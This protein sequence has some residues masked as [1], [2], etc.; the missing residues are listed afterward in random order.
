MKS[1][2]VPNRVERKVE[3]VWEP[4]RAAVDS[5]SEGFVL[6]DTDDRLVL[7]NPK[8]VKMY[9]GITDILQPG[10]KFEDVIRT[11]AERD[12][13]HLG[14]MSVEEYVRWRVELHRRLSG[15][16]EYHLNDGRC[17]LVNEWSTS[18][19]CTVS[20]H[21]DIT[22]LKHRESDLTQKSTLLQA[23]FDNIAEGISVFDK[24]LRLVAWNDQYLEAVGL[25]R[26]LARV[27]APIEELLR[28]RAK[29]GSYGPAETESH[30]RKRMKHFKRFPSEVFEVTRPDGRIF[31][32]RRQ[33]FPGGGIVTTYTDVTERKCTEEA[34]R[35]SQTW[36]KHAQHVAKVGHWVWYGPNIN[37]WIRDCGK[38]YRPPM[39]S[40]EVAR[41]FGIARN[42]TFEGEIKQEWETHPDDVERCAETLERAER[43]QSSYDIE[44][45]IVHPD[46]DVRTVHEIGELLHDEVGDE[47]TWVGVVQDVSAQTR[48]EADLISS[49]SRYRDLFEQSP[50]GIWEEDYSA[51]KEIIDGLRRR[52]VRNFRRYF[53]KHP[54]TLRKAIKA[55][56]VLDVNQAI[57]DIYR[58]PNKEAFLGAAR[59]FAQQ[60]A[61]ASFYEQELAALAEGSTRLTI[62]HTVEPLEGSDILVRSTTH[63]PEG[64]KDT[65]SL[66]IS[67]EE[68]ITERKQAEEA[69]RESEAR[70]AKAQRI[71]KVG[72]W[73]WD[74]KEDRE[75]YCSGEGERIFGVPH[76][77]LS[78]NFE[79]FLAMVH[80]NDRERLSGVGRR[81]VVRENIEYIVYGV[82]RN[83]EKIVQSGRRSVYVGYAHHDRRRIRPAV[84]VVDGIGERLRSEE[85]GG[86]RVQNA[87]PIIR[88]VDLAAVACRSHAGDGQCL[89]RIRSAGVV[90]E[91]IQRVVDAVLEYPDKRIV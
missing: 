38:G 15:P 10:A 13:E 58:A 32:G 41:I 47:H 50:I 48:L 71:A 43:E 44:Y 91:D 77:W 49:E 25:P 81:T 34:L 80:P 30:V 88:Y 20:V 14:G 59:K 11:C 61:E 60:A 19:G 57:L 9:P 75:S 45:R 27:G 63:I 64:T 72:H 39:I 17:V 68:D 62:E 87:V 31:E 16:F 40:D 66:V 82:R 2:S 76:E 90:G 26:K 8:Y 86:R 28:Y 4:L 35:E 24:D 54:K 67:T 89:A 23:I 33:P 42:Q 18:E 55:I 69:L 70:L 78:S 84:A 22:D 46:G 7:F 65:W 56:R 51:V 85:I 1:P 53:R 74:E 83:F 36:Q 37:D 5:I 29:R 52:G 3:P 21:T 12:G 73:V 6:W 79:E